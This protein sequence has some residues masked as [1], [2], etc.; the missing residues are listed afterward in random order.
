MVRRQR[1]KK[2]VRDPEQWLRSERKKL[3][4]KRPLA[5]AIDYSFNR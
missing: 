2:I 3:S 1:L 5:Q 4:P